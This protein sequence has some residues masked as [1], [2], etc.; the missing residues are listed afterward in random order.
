MN[1]HLSEIEYYVRVQFKIVR[2]ERSTVKWAS[3]LHPRHPEAKRVPDT[4]VKIRTAPIHFTIELKTSFAMN[5]P[6]LSLA[7]LLLFLQFCYGRI[8]T[9]LDAL[10]GAFPP[11]DPAIPEINGAFT[12]KIVARYDNITSGSFQRMFDFGNGQDAQNILMGQQESSTN[13]IFQYYTGGVGS[14]VELIAGGALTEGTTDTWEA[15]LDATGRMS[16]TKNGIELAFKDTGVA[17]LGSQTRS[18]KL[19]GRSNWSN[20]SDLEGAILGLQVINHSS[21]Q[22]YRTMELLNLQTQIFDHPFVASAYARFDDMARSYQRIFDIGNGPGDGNIIL[23]QNANTNH[24]SLVVFTD[25][26]VYHCPAY[27]AIVE[28]EM[29][30]WRAQVTASGIFRIEKNGVLLAECSSPGVSYIGDAVF[31]SNFHIGGSHWSEDDKLQG[32][33]LGLRIDLDDSS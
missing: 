32:L 11:N 31:R 21:S 1:K 22:D 30:L 23:S 27:N 16:I 13:V 20:D 7:Q 19:L 25:F 9:K 14:H 3:Y 33:I 18:N 17:L 15:S 28:G 26:G 2:K 29:A 8:I 5:T 10:D 6:I 4:V 12:V 24:M